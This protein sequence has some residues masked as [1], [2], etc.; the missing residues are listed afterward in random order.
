MNENESTEPAPKIIV[1]SDWKEQVA[2][3]KE[4]AQAENIGESKS[5]PAVDAPVEA[6]AESERITEP[7]ITEDR[8]ESADVS[9]ATN[10][11]AANPTAPNPTATPGSRLPPASFEVL[12]S[13]LFTQAIASLGQMPDPSGEDMQ[14][15]KPMAKHTIDTIEMLQSKTQGNLSGDE[16]KMVNEALH[17]LRMAYVSVRS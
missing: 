16:S 9:P 5:D 17:A 2:K 8:L 11:T 1:D 14:I 3:E 10:P 15:D 4:A 13:M 12:I 6:V 7:S